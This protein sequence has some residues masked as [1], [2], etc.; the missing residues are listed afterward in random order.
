M[1]NDYRDKYPMAYELLNNQLINNKLSHAYLIDENGDDGAWNFILSF[2]KS[3]V[4]KD[5]NFS[6]ES[7]EASV[8]CKKI[9]D[10]N[11]SEVKIIS[12]DGMYIKKQQI[13]D[14]QQ[15][16]SLSSIEGRRRIYIIK[17]VDKM[18]LEAANSML[19][20]LEEP[21]NN[22]IAILSTNNYNN[23]LSTIISRC[24]SINLNKNADLERTSDLDEF[25]LN[26]ISIVN[27]EGIYAFLKEK[28]LWTNYIQSK[29]REKIIELL[30]I[31]IDMYYDVLKLK[32]NFNKIKFGGYV[33]K[34]SR[35]SNKNSFENIVDIIDYLIL[36]KDSVKFNVNINLLVDSLIIKLGG[37]YGSC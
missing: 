29:D 5:L 25:V 16:F 22:I 9:D 2:V 21:D 8:L 30:D 20:F 28:E 15:S 27:D 32:N 33:D 14:L 34:L 18:R 12:A 23:V 17:D 3:I 26:F 31:M 7:N 13:L 36:T 24:Q 1:L 4:C 35:I 19:K 11:Y 37:L 6:D 10:G